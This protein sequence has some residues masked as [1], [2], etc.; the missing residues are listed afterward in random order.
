[1]PWQA[2]AGDLLEERLARELLHVEHAFAP[3]EPFHD[4]HG[5]GHGRDAGGIRHCLGIQLAVGLGMIAHVVDDIF[6]RPAVLHALH[7]AADGCLAGVVLGQRG[8]FRQEVLEKLQ[9]DDLHAVVHHRV[10][11]GHAN[12]LQDL[13]VLYVVVR[14][15]HPEA[16]LLEPPYVPD[17]GLLLLVVDQVGFALA[18]LG[19]VDHARDAQRV[20]LDPC[21]VFPESAAL[22]H[23]ADVDLRVEVGGKGLAVAAVV[24]VDDVYGMNLVE[25]VLLGI[26]AV[27][28]YHSGIKAAAEHRHDA[29]LAEAV[30]VGPLPCIAEP[31]LV[32][33][34]IVGRVQVVHP[35]GQAGIHDGQVLV[36]QGHVHHHMGP[37]LFDEPDDQGR[38]VR[39]DL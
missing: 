34:L 38:V 29:A 39:I 3:P 23:L 28:A 22:C 35:G 24:A 10:D 15:G 8:R 1:M 5:P 30:L 14:E 12:V 11:P 33:G 20:D 31:G 32:L 36:G 37:L 4:H 6:G 25:E 18:H 17:Q 7:D 26:C 13:Q 19:V 27:N 16:D 21:A 9:G 2:L